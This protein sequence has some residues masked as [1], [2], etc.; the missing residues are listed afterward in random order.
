MPIIYEVDKQ[1]HRCSPSRVVTQEHWDS[2]KK[3]FPK[4]NL[5]EEITATA[6]FEKIELLPMVETIA[7]PVIVENKPIETTKKAVSKLASTDKNKKLSNKK[8]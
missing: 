8:L 7:Q 1:G 4:T 6:T 5:R 2:I 3:N